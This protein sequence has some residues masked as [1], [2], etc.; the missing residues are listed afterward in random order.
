MWM[1]QVT[2]AFDET[3]TIADVDALVGAITGKKVSGE[4]ASG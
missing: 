3:S 2:V 4:N 1:W